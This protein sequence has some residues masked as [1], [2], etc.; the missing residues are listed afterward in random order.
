MFLRPS[1]QF[2]N[3]RAEND[4][5]KESS[6]RLVVNEVRTPLP[7]R[8]SSA[9]ESFKGAVMETVLLSVLCQSLV[10]SHPDVEVWPLEPDADDAGWQ[11]FSV[12]SNTNG[13]V[14]ILAYLRL[15][16]DRFE[17]RAYDDNGDDLWL[18]AS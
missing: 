16:D 13:A 17:R 7:K 12:V 10:A 2:L 8:R 15:L 4:G 3:F 5:S 11:Y 6:T 1:Q 18:P 9:E 14:R